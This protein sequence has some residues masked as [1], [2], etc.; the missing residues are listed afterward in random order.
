MAGLKS[1]NVQLA[2]MK[3][4]GSYTTEQTSNFCGQCHRTWEEIAAGGLHGIVNVRFQPY[5]VTNSRCYDTEDK[6]ISCVACHNPHEE[7]SRKDIDYD[8][9]CQACHSKT[10]KTAAKICRVAKEDCVSCHMPKLELPGS[11][12]KFTDHDIRI[13][14]ASAKSVE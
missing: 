12:H 1:G 5:G 8:T 10:G 2:Q 4:L 11:H 6:R 9:K 7:I 14:R 3:R 13:V